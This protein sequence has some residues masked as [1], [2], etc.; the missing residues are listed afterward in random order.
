[1]ARTYWGFASDPNTR[2]ISLGNYHIDVDSADPAAVE[3]AWAIYLAAREVDKRRTAEM[4]AKTIAALTSAG[5]DSPGE[6]VMQVSP[7]SELRIWLSLSL[8]AASA[9]CQTRM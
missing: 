4:R 9:E 2:T 7:G 1:M 6:A 5:M 3:L 8:P